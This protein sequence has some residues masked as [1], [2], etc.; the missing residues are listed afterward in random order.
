MPKYLVNESELRPLGKA[1]RPTQYKKEYCHQVRRMVRNCW[2]D[3]EIADFFDIGETTLYK[4]KKIHP[5][6][7]EAFSEPLDDKVATENVAKSL[8]RRATGYT[9]EQE[10]LVMV[11]RGQV[12]KYRYW[13]HLPPD[14]R[15]I[16]FWLKNKAPDVW[17]ERSEMKVDQTVISKDMRE[18]E[19]L[20]AHATPE[21]IE[22]IR[23]LYEEI[24]ERVKKNKPPMIDGKAEEVEE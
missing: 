24:E 17:R 15:S 10:K 3:R 6:F 23:Q 21:E 22:T 7:R 12:K 5:E 16:E 8:F 20:L 11:G 18:A 4:W 9:Y 19:N 13:V 2:Q 14:P 1:G